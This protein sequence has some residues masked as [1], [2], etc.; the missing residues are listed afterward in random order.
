[1]KMGRG[2]ATMLP[3]I[4]VMG[5]SATTQSGAARNE[6]PAADSRLPRTRAELTNYTE[7]SRY[8]DVVA[9]L[10]SL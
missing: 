3:V 9:F 1:M 8:S 6:S 4:L 5:C 7:T 10:D 2:V